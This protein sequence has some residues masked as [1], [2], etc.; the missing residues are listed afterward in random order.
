[1]RVTVSWALRD[2]RAHPAHEG[3]V[4]R[5]DAAY[6]AEDSKSYVGNSLAFGASTSA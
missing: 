3:Q 6:G 4:R 2:I 5:I 1:M